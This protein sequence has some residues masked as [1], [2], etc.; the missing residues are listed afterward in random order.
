MYISSSRAVSIWHE[1]F[2][3]WDLKM[4][5]YDQYWTDFCNNTNSCHLAWGLQGKWVGQPDI[6]AVDFCRAPE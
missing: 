3:V 4:P 2:S 6:Q 1:G 5:I